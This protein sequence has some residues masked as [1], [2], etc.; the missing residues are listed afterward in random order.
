MQPRTFRD[1]IFAR[2]PLIASRFD[3]EALAWIKLDIHPN[4]TEAR[5]LEKIDGKPFL[6]LEYVSGGDL[7]AWIGTPRLTED[8]SQL[9]DSAFSSAT[10]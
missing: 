5:M 8:F 7:G 10:E 2:S 1:E 4:I 6:F 9:L 3:R